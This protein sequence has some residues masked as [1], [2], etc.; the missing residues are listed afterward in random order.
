MP[1]TDAE[2]AQAEANKN[3]IRRLFDEVLTH[4]QLDMID[5]LYHEDYEFDAPA[6]AGSGAATSS[7]REAFK[8]RVV[9]FRQAFP[10][11]KYIV[12]DFIGEGDLVVTKM[13]M[14]GTHKGPFAGFAPTGRFS[15]IT[16]IHVAQFL[17]GKI[18]KTWAGF[19]NIA[20]ALKP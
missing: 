17:D 1:T 18:R 11:M 9:A 6:L 10:D 5:V 4:D 16:G 20:E 7:G 19:T 3:T 15:E 12:Q 13:L 8:Q 14:T 2:R